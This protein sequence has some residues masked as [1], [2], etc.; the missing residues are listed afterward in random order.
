VGWGDENHR[1]RLQALGRDPELGC[2]GGPTQRGRA[3]PAPLGHRAPHHDGHAL[4]RRVAYLHP[5]RQRYRNLSPTRTAAL[6]LS[7][8]RHRR[9]PCRSHGSF[10]AGSGSGSLNGYNRSTR[11]TRK[12]AGRQPERLSSSMI[13]WFLSRSFLLCISSCIQPLSVRTNLPITL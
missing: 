4:R 12:S 2:A 9:P 7:G 8:R 11:S 1:K 3:R 13:D 5:A 6:D 10:S